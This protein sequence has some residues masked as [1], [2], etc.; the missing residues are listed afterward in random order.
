MDSTKSDE[1][2]YERIGGHEGLKRLLTHFYADVRQHAVIGPIFQAQIPDWPLHI[3][4]IAGFWSG[5]T[6]GPPLYGG[7]MIAKHMPLNLK[8]DHFGHWLT[9]WAFQ[10]DRNLNPKDAA[11]MKALANQIGDRL[12]QFAMR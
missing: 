12:K 4:K 6:G 5:L 7:G 2:L 10:C 8:P 1:T 3:E 11:M 9:L